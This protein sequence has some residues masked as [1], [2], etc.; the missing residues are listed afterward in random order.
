MASAAPSWAH[1]WPSARRRL[2]ALFL[3]TCSAASAGSTTSSSFHDSARLRPA[4]ALLRH[5]APQEEAGERVIPFLAERKRG[6]VTEMTRGGPDTVECLNR[7]RGFESGSL[8]RRVVC[9]PG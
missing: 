2:R 3:R 4:P 8:Q 7:D 6:R 5:G 9:K 1:S